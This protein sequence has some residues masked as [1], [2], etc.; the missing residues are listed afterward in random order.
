MSAKYKSKLQRQGRIDLGQAIPLETPMLLYVD[1]SSAC[2]FR[3]CFCPSGHH[4]LMKDA[5]VKGTILDFDVYKKMIDGLGEFSDKVKVIR[6]N[7]IGEPLL[8]PRIAD[9]IR[10]AMD[11]GH[12]ESTHITTNAS[13]LT[14]ELSAELLASGINVINISIEGVSNEQYN[15]YCNVEVDFEKIVREVA[16]LYDHRNDTKITVKIPGNYLSEEDKER[17]ME[18][19]SDICDAIFVENLSS[20]WPNFDIAQSGRFPVSEAHQY[21]EADVRK[22]VCTYLFYA[23][24][25]NADGTVSACCPDWEQKLILGDANTQSLKEIWNGPV[26]RDMQMKHLNFKRDSIETCGKCGHIRYCQVDSIDDAVGEI[27]KRM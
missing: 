23:M 21:G 24:A 13:R 2:N 18:L 10:Y 20:I 3:C 19:F 16:W 5:G 12:V 7:K 11:S 22:E 15:E 6:Y 9:M 27:L 14:P 8:N 26:I 1:P 25:I 4:Q 17:F